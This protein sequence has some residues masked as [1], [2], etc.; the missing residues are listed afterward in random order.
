[1]NTNV[2]NAIAFILIIFYV[3]DNKTLKTQNGLIPLEV[4]FLKDSS[5]NKI[6]ER[7]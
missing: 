4:R 7:F 2:I 1:M 6:K 5:N 3:Y